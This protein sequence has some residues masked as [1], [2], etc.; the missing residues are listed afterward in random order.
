MPIYEY[1]CNRCQESFS[2]LQSIT[3]EK[4]ARCPKC[5]SAEVKKKV[6]SFCSIGGVGGGTGSG[7]SGSFGSFGGG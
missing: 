2:V 7:F 4:D 3:A 5:G 1:V 6:S